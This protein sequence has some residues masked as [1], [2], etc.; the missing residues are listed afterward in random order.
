MEPDTFARGRGVF[1]P[2]P[3]TKFLPRARGTSREILMSRDRRRMTNSKIDQLGNRLR[4]Q[5]VTESDERLLD[6]YRDLF[7]GP[8]STVMRVLEDQIGLQPTARSSKTV[9][10][11]VE[12]LQR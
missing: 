4:S 3:L 6:E 10:A 9:Q 8:G 1:T 5:A 11:I 7:A 12:K 2:K